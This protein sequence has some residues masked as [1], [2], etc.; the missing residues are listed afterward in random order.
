MRMTMNCTTTISGT[1]TA[2]TVASDGLMEMAAISAPMSMPGARR[3]MRMSMLIMFM[4]W[5]TSLVRRVMSEP[6]EKRSMLAKENF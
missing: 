4:T 1:V 3:H 5:V 2:S 6:V